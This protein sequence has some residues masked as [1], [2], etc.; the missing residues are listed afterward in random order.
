[1]SEQ[2]F[3]LLLATDLNSDN[4]GVL[5]KA[6]ALSQPSNVKLSLI[7][8]VEG[9]PLYFGNDM[10]LPEM[11]EIEGQMF[12]LAQKRMAE[13]AEK[14]AIPSLNCHVKSGVAKFVITEFAKENAVDLIVIG[15]HSRHGLSQF[16]G[17]TARAVLNKADCDVL[18]VKVK[19]EADN[20]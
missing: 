17:S 11:M 12:D 1:M 9:V 13:W 19:P 20:R 8:V 10:V 15:S 18:A 6:Q 2:Y 5:A 3:H 14:Y 16:L 4:S 7:H